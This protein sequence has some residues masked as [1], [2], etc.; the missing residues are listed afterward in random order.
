MK[1]SSIDSVVNDIKRG[2]LAIVVDDEDRENEGDLV[3]GAQ[4]AD[5]A[6]VNF[7]ARHGRGIICVP[8]MPQRLEELGIGMMAAEQSQDT[9]RT[10]WATSVD[11]RNGVTTGISAHD[12]ALTIRKLVDPK[13]TD[14][15][16][17]KPGHIFPLKARPGGVLVRAG[18][19]EAAIDLVRLAGLEP[20]GVVC[21]IMNDDG[22]MARLPDLIKFSRQHHLKICTIRDL[23]E[24]R[25]KKEKLVHRVA[26]TQITN[27]FGTFKL[28]AYES[29]VDAHYHLALVKGNPA[30]EKEV[31]VRVHSECLTGDVFGSKR[32]D[33]GRQLKSSIRMIAKEKTGVVLYMRQEGRGIGL[34][35]KLKA[36]ELQDAG[37]DTV[38]ANV[39]LG[40]K[41][42]LRHYGVG[43]QILVDLGVRNIRLLT[44]NPKKIIGLGGYGLRVVER[45]PI[46]VEPNRHNLR[47]LRTKKRK[48]GHYLSRAYR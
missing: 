36:Y 39:K 11:A 28:V 34:V 42:D 18:H 47:Y 41:P 26:Q 15:D 5:A 6:K 2:K 32:C 48:L 37:L 40:F 8:M 33:C 31:L 3:M 30:E 12:R 16:F 44:N 43:A 46:E 45:V 13:A 35:N 4:F 20:V 22:S 27:E 25:R 21:E 1:L 23:I 24:Y 7:M 17:I 9:F 38:E 29:V 19:T 10:A 14:K